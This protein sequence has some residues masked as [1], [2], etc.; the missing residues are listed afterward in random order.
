MRDIELGITTLAPK[1]EMGASVVPL[2]MYMKHTTP[3]LSSIT[4]RAFDMMTPKDNTPHV[5]AY[6]TDNAQ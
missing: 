5:R 2:N 6:R 4:P 3:A 1:K